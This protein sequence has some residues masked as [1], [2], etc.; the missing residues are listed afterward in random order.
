VPEKICKKCNV[1]GMV[2]GVCFRDATR[3][4]AKSLDV[5]GSAINLRDGS[6]E[7]LAYGNKADVDALCAWL[8]NGSGMSQVQAVVCDNY[9]INKLN[10][11]QRELFF[12]G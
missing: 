6:V 1:A 7:V 9:V 12:I 3:R 4:K 11:K 5:C 2:Q 10:N 8:W